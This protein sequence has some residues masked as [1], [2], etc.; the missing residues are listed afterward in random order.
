LPLV[1][2]SPTSP[3]RL[4]NHKNKGHIKTK[5]VEIEIRVFL[6]FV[7]PATMASDLASHARAALASSLAAR[8]VA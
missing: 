7:L 3:S 1:G 5:T 6:E 2:G 8:R 4:E